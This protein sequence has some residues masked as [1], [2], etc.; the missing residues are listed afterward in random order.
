MDCSQFG[1]MNRSE[2][3]G[4]R[5]IKQPVNQYLTRSVRG[6]LPLLRIFPSAKFSQARKIGLYHDQRW[7]GDWLPQ[8]LTGPHGP[9]RGP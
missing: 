3:L 8:P 2:L 6:S 4:P 5:R 1:R 7:S 9:P